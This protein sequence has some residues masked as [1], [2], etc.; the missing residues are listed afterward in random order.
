MGIPPETKPNLAVA[1]T[2]LLVDDELSVLETVACLLELDGYRVLT[3]ASGQEALDVATREAVDAILLDVQ[4]PN[5]DGF[6]VLQELGRRPALA[7]I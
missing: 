3:A 6:Q 4:M 2:L 7:S 5:M 1:G